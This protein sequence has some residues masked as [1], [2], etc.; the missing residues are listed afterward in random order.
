MKHWFS[1]FQYKAYQDVITDVIS[2]V[3]EHF[4]EDGVDETVLQEL[5]QLWETKLAATKAVD[6]N[7]EPDKVV[8]R[9]DNYDFLIYTPVGCSLQ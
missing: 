3:K 7:K 1:L 4:I 8:G 5:R 6:E 2:N 9:W